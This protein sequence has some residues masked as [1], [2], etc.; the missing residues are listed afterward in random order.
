MGKELN[1]LPCS[2]IARKMLKRWAVSNKSDGRDEFKLLPYV[3]HACVV[4][5]KGTTFYKNPQH[6]STRQRWN[7]LSSTCSRSLNLTVTV[8]E[9]TND[10][11]YDRHSYNA[12]ALFLFIKP[13]RSL[14]RIQKLN[15]FLELTVRENSGRA[16]TWK[17]RREKLH[18]SVTRL[19]QTIILKKIRIS[20]TIRTMFALA[21]VDKSAGENIGAD[22]N[23]PSLSF[24]MT[25]RRKRKTDPRADRR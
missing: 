15:G 6:K 14:S 21:R 20:E 18:N 3:S 17:R 13:S 25:S 8:L 24:R 23:S 19:F 2:Y 11:K 4:Q 1:F 10:W 7:S 9:Y 16:Q 22:C 12:G 5:M